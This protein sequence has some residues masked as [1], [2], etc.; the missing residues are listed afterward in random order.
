MKVNL[1]NFNSPIFIAEIGMNYNNNFDLCF[2][3]IKQAKN[4]GANFAKFQLGW[5]DKEGEINQISEEK[6]ALLHD[7]GEYFDINILFSIISEDAFKKIV[8]FNPKFLKI[9]SRTIKDNPNLSKNLLDVGVP[10]F[11]SLGMWNE[12]KPPYDLNDQNNLFYLW[13]KS[14]YP[15]HPIDMVDLPKTFSNTIYTG[16]SDHT[17]GIETCLIALSRGAAIIEKHF[18]LDKSENIIRDH[19]LSATP[20]EFKNLVEIG[21]DIYKKIKLGV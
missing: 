15:C 10:T 13:C 4:S 8:K 3:M 2:E 11:C 19:S 1:L 20:N 17:I 12:S 14:K 9:A 5:R 18:T 7:W 16:Y 6:I 21:T